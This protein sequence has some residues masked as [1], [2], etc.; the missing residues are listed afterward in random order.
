MKEVYLSKRLRYSQRSNFSTSHSPQALAW[1]SGADEAVK[2]FQRFRSHVQSVSVSVSLETVKTVL[3]LVGP[4]R[5]QAKA[6]AELEVEN[7]RDSV[8]HRISLWKK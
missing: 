8:R 1:V 3:G 2:P 4:L 5:P 7:R 6:W